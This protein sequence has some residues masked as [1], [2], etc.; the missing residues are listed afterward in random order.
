LLYCNSSPIAPTN[1]HTWTWNSAVE[2]SVEELH[3]GVRW[4]KFDFADW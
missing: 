3:G 2:L 1:W 4:A